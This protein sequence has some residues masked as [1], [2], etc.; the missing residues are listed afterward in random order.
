MTE[1]GTSVA[2]QYV[3]EELA[4]LSRRVDEAMTGLRSDVSGLAGE[5]RGHMAEQG[6]RVAVLE[7]RVAEAEKDITALQVQHEKDVADLRVQHEKD[8][9][10]IR[11]AKR[12]SWQAWLAIGIATVSALINWI[13]PMIGK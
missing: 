11:E 4:T 13:L 3:R 6:P 5:L 8:I 9:G 12:T 2:L 1:D 10:A 7:Q